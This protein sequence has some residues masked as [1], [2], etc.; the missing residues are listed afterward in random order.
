MTKPVGGRFR[1]GL[2]TAADD[3]RAAGW[4]VLKPHRVRLFLSRIV[5][6]WQGSPTGVDSRAGDL[7]GIVTLW[8]TFTAAYPL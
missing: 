5:E 3:R 8:M 4:P 7:A 2:S 6:Y 1:A